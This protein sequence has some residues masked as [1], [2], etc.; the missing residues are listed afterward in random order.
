[1]QIAILMGA[2]API[3]IIMPLLILLPRLYLRVKAIDSVPKQRRL[4]LQKFSFYWTERFAFAFVTWLGFIGFQAATP[5]INAFPSP[6]TACMATLPGDPQSVISDSADTKALCY[7]EYM[8]GAHTLAFL[9][10]LAIC[11]L[12]PLWQWKLCRKV[13]YLGL[14]DEVVS[15]SFGNRYGSLYAANGRG[16]KRYW[17]LVVYFNTTVLIGTLSL[18]LAADVNLG[19]PISSIVVNGA[20]MLGFIFLCPSAERFDDL[21]ESYFL[22]VQIISLSLQIV[23]NDP[24]PIKPAKYEINQAVREA[25]HPTRSSTPSEIGAAM[26]AQ[27]LPLFSA[28]AVGYH[29]VPHGI[30]HGYSRISVGLR[31]LGSGL[32]RQLRRLEATL[33]P[34]YLRDLGV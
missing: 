10:V 22:A 17:G 23:A 8:A 34:M 12:F 15:E 6:G 2:G 30:R 19:L 32:G 26:R 27:H 20:V 7:S 18:W 1:M 28:G 9:V 3:L 21:V 11:V 5:S 29:H 14:E 13:N 24:V 31:L 25:L 4:A 33:F 16:W